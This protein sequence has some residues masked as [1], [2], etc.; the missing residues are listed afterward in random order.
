MSSE[1]PGTKEPATD[2]FARPFHN[3]GFSV[4]AFNC[5]ES[6]SAVAAGPVFQ[7]AARDRRLAAAIAQTPTADSLTGP[8][9][10]PKHTETPSLGHPADCPRS[11]QAGSV[12]PC[13]CTDSARPT[14]QP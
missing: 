1:R 2:T 12:W 14:R 9:H 10:L 3:A 13:F 7:V 5:R 6:A 4:L 8:P 11:V